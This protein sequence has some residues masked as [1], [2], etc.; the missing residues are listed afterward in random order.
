[1][2][3]LIWAVKNKQ[4]FRQ[5]Q[6]DYDIP[7]LHAASQHVHEA[8]NSNG[9]LS[10]LAANENNFG[11]VKWAEWQ[12]AFGCTPVEYE[13]VWEVVGGNDVYEP[14]FFCHC[15]NFDTWLKIYAE[16]LSIPRYVGAKRFCKDPFLY[17]LHIFK[18]GYATDPRYIEGIGKWMN[19]LWDDYVDTI[20]GI[21]YGGALTLDGGILPGPYWIENDIMLGPIDPLISVI[22]DQGGKYKWLQPVRT[23]EIKTR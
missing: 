15:P 1:M 22:V 19:I 11:G 9:L 18:S 6:H 21:K 13:A 3:Q 10:E 2:N 20:G 16:L 12:R 4:S 14:A 5:L 8:F 7:A 17:S 23:G